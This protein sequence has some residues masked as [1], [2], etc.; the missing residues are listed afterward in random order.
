MDALN[1]N[2]KKL[3]T[4]KG[5]SQTEFARL[6][7]LSRANIGSYEEGRA[8]P[9]MEAVIKIANHFS[10]SLD[11]FV[12]RELSVN[13]FLRFEAPDDLENTNS[14]STSSDGF[15]RIPF[16]TKVEL[17][18]YISLG[19]AKNHIVLPEEY[20]ADL[21]WQHEGNHLAG[22][23]GIEHHSV[24]LLKSIDPQSIRHGAI[25]T[26]L[27]EKEFVTGICMLD[28]KMV[29]LRGMNDDSELLKTEIKDIRKAWSLS[30][31]LGQHSANYE[32][33]LLKERIQELENTLQN[34][35]DS[36]TKMKK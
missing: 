36:S 33:I 14:L 3:R 4:L 27:H 16:I 26:I 25:H 19:R 12:N 9:K 11:D 23:E 34:F 35:I 8:Q 17:S 20:T 15:I 32:Y 5:L 13:D 6:F 22:S 1:K 2:I 29:L 21:A 28:G 31:V 18:K 10:I 30:S 7:D 24:L